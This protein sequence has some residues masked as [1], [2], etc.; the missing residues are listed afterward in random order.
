[1]QEDI[2]YRYGTVRDLKAL[3]CIAVFENFGYRQIHSFWRL[4]G[5]MKYI[6]VKS[7]R[8]SG[9]SGWTSIQRA[10]FTE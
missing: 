3:L 4:W 8:S 6:F 1:V 5:M 7:S 10:S 2:K 9:L